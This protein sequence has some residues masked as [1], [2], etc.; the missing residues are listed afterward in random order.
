LCARVGLLKKHD[1]VTRESLRIVR[2]KITWLQ[3]QEKYVKQEDIE[4][5]H[6]RTEAAEQRAETLHVSLGAARMDVRDLIESHEAHWFEM[7]ELRSRAQ[8]IET[9]FWDLE[10]HLETMTI[11]NQGLSITKIKHIIT[12]RVASAI[13]TIAIYETKTRVAHESMNQTKRQEDKMAKNA[14]NKRKWEGD[15]GTKNTK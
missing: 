7:A 13:E 1:V 14:S 11:M 6:V 3:L 5:S 2:G 12:Q 4:A 15:H 10:R 9:S 8:D